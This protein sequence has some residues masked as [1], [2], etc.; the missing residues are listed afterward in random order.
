MH[1]TRS[2]SF[3]LGLIVIGSSVFAADGEQMLVPEKIEL[4]S[5]QTGGWI[6]WEGIANN[7]G[8][9]VL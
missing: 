8:A 6:H 2:L 7:E 5:T 3:A 9:S 4:G 1:S